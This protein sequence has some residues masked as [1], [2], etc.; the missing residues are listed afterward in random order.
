MPLTT[1]VSSVPFSETAK[2]RIDWHYF[3]I[4]QEGEK[5]HEKKAENV[6]RT[7]PVHPGEGRGLH[8][9]IR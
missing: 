5:K 7:I 6:W 1:L 4:I 2:P 9:T 8:V 3:R